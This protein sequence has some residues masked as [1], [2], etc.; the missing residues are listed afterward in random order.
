MISPHP[1]MT[2]A[3]SVLSLPI[4]VGRSEDIVHS[5]SRRGIAYGGVMS[6]VDA[7]R[8]LIG[9]EV[10]A[11]AHPNFSVGRGNVPCDVIVLHG[12][13]FGAPS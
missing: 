7:H 11:L 9:G 8:G 2:V 13:P 6:L 4:P 5:L 12:G 3:M 1:V 10:I